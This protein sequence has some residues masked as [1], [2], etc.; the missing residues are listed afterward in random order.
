MKSSFAKNER[1]PLYTSSISLCSKL[2]V[3]PTAEIYSGESVF[4][5]SGFIFVG[6]KTVRIICEAITNHELL[7]WLIL[8]ST[9][10]MRQKSIREGSM[11]AQREM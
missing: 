3:K 5:A 7:H 6:E 4:E 9:A 1:V 8:H 10:I 11:D 2:C